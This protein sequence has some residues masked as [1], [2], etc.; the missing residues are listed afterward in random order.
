R[1]LTGVQGIAISK[2]NAVDVVRHPLVARI[3]EAYEAADPAP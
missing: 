2:F 1:I 3:I